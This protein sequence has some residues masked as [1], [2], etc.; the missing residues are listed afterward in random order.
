[1]ATMQWAPCGSQQQ[2]NSAQDLQR[3]TM[4]AELRRMAEVPTIDSLSGAGLPP[5]AAAP[6]P[7]GS[8]QLYG[9]RASG[10][11]QLYTVPGPAAA[12][13]GHGQLLASARSAAGVLSGM[14]TLPTLQEQQAAM[15]EASMPTVQALA[16]ALQQQAAGSS[17]A[18]PGTVFG[19]C[20]SGAS[21]PTAML[22]SGPLLPAP[23][24][25][26]GCFTPAGETAP[27]QMEP[28]RPHWSIPAPDPAAAAVA[29]RRGGASSTRKSSGEAK[30]RRQK[31]ACCGCC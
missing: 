27:L 14:R 19:T 25:R 4:A 2:L 10:S 12:R 22:S 26:Q 6:L 21:G 8:G 9:G 11:S 1:M 18:A 23:C 13:D 3:L 20:P 31:A 30:A 5:H 24:S 17:T 16:P 29:A 28:E 15:Q 7:L